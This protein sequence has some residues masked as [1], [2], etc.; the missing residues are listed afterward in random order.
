MNFMEL[1]SCPVCKN[2]N[3]SVNKIVTLL[4]GV[5]YDDVVCPECGATWKFYYKITDAQ[6]EVTSA[7]EIPHECHCGNCGKNDTEEATEVA[8]VTAE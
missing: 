2:R 6:V 1:Q 5:R 3:I 7:P 4:E 8:E